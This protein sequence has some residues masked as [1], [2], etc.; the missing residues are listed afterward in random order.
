[1]VG[2]ACTGVGWGGGG[3]PWWPAA[4]GWGAGVCGAC[5]GTYPCGVCC[6]AGACGMCGAGAGGACWVWAGCGAGAGGGAKAG[7][8][9]AGAASGGLRCGCLRLLFL[10]DLAAEVPQQRLQAAVEALT[11][12]GEPPDVLDVEVAE[13]HGALG[14]EL[15]TVEG[16]PRDLLA[17]GHDPQVARADLGHLA[18]AVERRGEGQLL[19][20]RRN[21]LQRHPERLGV[22]RLRPEQLEGLLGRRGLVEEDEVPVVGEAFVGV[23]TE[24]ADVEAQPRS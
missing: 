8:A 10:Q 12:G 22:A 21:P 13:H 20:L 1:M 9:K 4:C 3:G 24:A 19:D 6:G 23:E 16:V 5:G 15:R 7:G 11:D 17:A 14:A 18:G 2:A